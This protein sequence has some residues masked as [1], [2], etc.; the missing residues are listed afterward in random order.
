MKILSTKWSKD[1]SGFY[2]LPFVAFSHGEYG[3]RLWIGWFKYLW[4]IIFHSNIQNSKAY[5]ECGHELLGDTK[6]KV[7]EHKDYT[8]IICSECATQTKWDLDAPV[9]IFLGKHKDG[10]LTE[11]AISITDEHFKTVCKRIEE[12][13]SGEIITDYMRALNGVKL[14][15]EVW[16][17]IADI[18]GKFLNQTNPHPHQVRVMNENI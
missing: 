7:Y 5:C 14:P 1:D 4:T 10:E 17:K 6:S 16:L 12:E 18:N 2:I 8:N 13:Q 11:Y 9:P 3:N 15:E